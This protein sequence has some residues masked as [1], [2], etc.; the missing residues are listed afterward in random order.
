MALGRPIHRTFRIRSVGLAFLP[1]VIALLLSGVAPAGDIG[2]PAA[3][4]IARATVPGQPLLAIRARTVGGVASYECDL[5][6]QPP[7]TF[8]SVAVARDSGAV[9]AVDSIPVP[10]DEYLP[11]VQALQRLN[12]ATIDFTQAES[13]AVAAAGVRGLERLELLYEQGVL[14]YRARFASGALLEVDSITGSIIPVPVPGFGI[15]TTVSAAEMAGAIAHAQWMSGSQWIAIEGWA[16]QRPDGI[17]IRVLMANRF[18]DTLRQSDVVLGIHVG[19]PIVE[20]LPFQIPLIQAVRPGGA[21]R[22]TAVEAIT[23]IETVSP[24]HGVNRASLQWLPGSAEPTWRIGIVT[25]S[26]I[27]RDAV[28]P[29]TVPPQG[30]VVELQPPRRSVAADVNWDGAVNAMDLGMV[31]AWWGQWH[32]TLDIDADGI[33]GGGDLGVIVTAWGQ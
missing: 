33:V 24:G 23:R 10:P 4:S 18:N 29:A 11:T 25:S 6:D 1:Q 14:A 8:T 17:I 9:V 3:A 28:M 7:T 27:E 2:F 13:R 30:A 5:V 22:G 16:V 21:V 15:E 31:L 12:Y 26:S 20:A 32:P 19:G